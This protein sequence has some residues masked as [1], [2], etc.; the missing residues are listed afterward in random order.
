MNAS[1]ATSSR[2][3]AAAR[4]FAEEGAKVVLAARTETQLKAVAEQVRAEGGVADYLRC[5]LTD[6]ASVQAAIDQVL[7]LHGRLNL[8]FNNGATATPPR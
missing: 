3:G 5:D 6:P 1:R 4:L 8:A 7:E 2:R